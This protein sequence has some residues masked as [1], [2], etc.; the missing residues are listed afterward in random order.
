MSRIVVNYRP[1]VVLGEGMFRRTRLYPIDGGHRTEPPI[2]FLGRCI[3]GAK[4][5]LAGGHRTGIAVRLTLTRRQP[6]PRIPAHAVTAFSD[7]IFGALTPMSQPDPIP[8]VPRGGVEPLQRRTM[9]PSWLISAVLHFLVLML[10]V[11]LP[12]WSTPRGGAV[13]ERTAEVGIVLKHQQQQ[14]DQYYEGQG[15]SAAADLA[16]AAANADGLDELLS[17]QPSADPSRELPSSLAVIG[18]G[19]LEGGAVGTAMG[20]DTGPRGNGG[21]GEG[22]GRTSVF[23]IQGEGYKFAYVFDRSGS[24]TGTALEAAKQQLIASLKSLEETHQFQIVFYNDRVQRFSPTGEPNKLFFASQRNKNLAEKFI[25]SRVASGGTN[26]EQAL[27]LAIN[28]RPDVIF[29]LTDANPPRLWPGQL[30]KVRQRAAGITIN[31]IEFGFGPQS[32]ANNFLVKL[33]R[34]NGGKHGYVDISNRRWVPRK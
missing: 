27:M 8:S 20:A 18:P 12:L 16:A 6:G 28:L 14:D 1:G 29:F 33:A 10:A 21:S 5:R 31:A 34:D 32:E 25:G 19:A 3:I 15:D 30:A 24:M 26:H 7:S 11:G 23:G 17:D 2:G 13:A 4:L 9:L 22:K